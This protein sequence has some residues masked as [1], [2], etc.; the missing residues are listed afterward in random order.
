MY[1]YVEKPTRSPQGLTLSLAEDSLDLLQN[2]I[3]PNQSR[4]ISIK[5]VNNS[6]E[7]VELVIGA[8]VGFEKG[9]IEDLVKDGEILIK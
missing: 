3:K 8:L 5:V 1:Y 6:E 2:T 4:N 7:Q 9:N